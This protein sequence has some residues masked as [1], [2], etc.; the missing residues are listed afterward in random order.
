LIVRAGDPRALGDAIRRLRDDPAL[1]A[2]LGANAREAVASYT[3]EAWADAMS[4][5]IAAARGSSKHDRSGCFDGPLG[6]LA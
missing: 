4:R 6:L 5:A 2:R 3:H 1:R